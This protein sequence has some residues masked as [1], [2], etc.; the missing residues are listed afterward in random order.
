MRKRIV[1]RGITVLALTATLALAGAHAAGAQDLGLLERGLR[2]LSDF[3][4]LPMAPHQGTTAQPQAQQ[5]S[6]SGSTAP[7]PG[8]TIVPGDK[9]LGVDPNGVV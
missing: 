4:S 7:A 3:W 1:H 9:G 8:Q 5:Q 6:T 2:W